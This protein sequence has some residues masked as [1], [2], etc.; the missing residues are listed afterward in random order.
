MTN[1]NF[2]ASAIEK[3]IREAAATR[4]RARGVYEA[5]ATKAGQKPALPK[6]PATWT[7]APTLDG[8]VRQG[9]LVSVLSRRDEFRF[10]TPQA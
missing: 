8:L 6:G 1:V 5:A 2:D 7:P 10:R 3:L 4:D 9:E